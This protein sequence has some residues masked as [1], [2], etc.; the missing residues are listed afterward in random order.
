MCYEESHKK[1]VGGTSTLTEA[2]KHYISRMEIDGDRVEDF[3]VGRS[4]VYLLMAADKQENASI[5]PDHPEEKDLI[6]FYQKT[7]ESGDK[8]W[9]FM[10]KADYEQQKNDLPD[11]CFATRHPIKQLLE[12]VQRE[13]LGTAT[14]E[15]KNNTS[16]ADLSTIAA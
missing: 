5:D 8:I 15:D 14:E 1:H 7:T 11:V 3:A 13:R 16:F 12:R 2:Y 4:C 9:K 6:H 10:T